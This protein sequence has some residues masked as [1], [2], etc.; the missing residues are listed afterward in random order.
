MDAILGV[1]KLLQTRNALTQP[2]SICPS[3]WSSPTLNIPVLPA[4]TSFSIPWYSMYSSGCGTHTTRISARLA[5]SNRAT[6][7]SKTKHS[8]GRI[9]TLPATTC[10]SP[11]P[12]PA[13][14]YPAPASTFPPSAADH[15]QESSSSAETRPVASW[16]R[17]WKSSTQRRALGRSRQ[18][19]LNL[20]AK[21]IASS[22]Q[23]RQHLFGSRQRL[24]EGEILAHHLAQLDGPCLAGYIWGQLRPCRCLWS[25]R[26]P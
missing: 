5:A 20:I 25:L 7:S 14:K 2:S 16:S 19:Q 4:R 13:G 22:A 12:T 23:V 8:L 3:C 6:L 10:R 15:H 17:A 21:V 24:A 18:R 9:G 26:R 1:D 11:P